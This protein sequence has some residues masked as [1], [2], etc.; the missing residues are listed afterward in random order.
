VC[1]Y[2]NHATN[3]EVPCLLQARG[4]N[5]SVNSQQGACRMVHCTLHVTRICAE[6]TQSAATRCW[7]ILAPSQNTTPGSSSRRQKH[8]SSRTGG[9]RG[10]AS[11]FDFANKVA[12]LSDECVCWWYRQSKVEHSTDNETNM[13]PSL[14]STCGGACSCEIIRVG[15]QQA[16]QS[17]TYLTQHNT[18]RTRTAARH[19]KSDIWS[20][21]TVLAALT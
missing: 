17:Q 7:D 6:T 9:S 12:G 19:C 8:G 1:L 20:Q 15:N 18:H 10:L 4:S 2:K 3:N 21:H 11:D 13:Q 5:N 16:K 14:Q